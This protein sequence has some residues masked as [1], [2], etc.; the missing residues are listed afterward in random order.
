MGWTP[1]NKISLER[2]FKT[3]EIIIKWHDDM[4]GD[5]EKRFPFEQKKE[6]MEFVA[7]EFNNLCM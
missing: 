6:A 1:V 7:H 4:L 5:K 3:R 2:D